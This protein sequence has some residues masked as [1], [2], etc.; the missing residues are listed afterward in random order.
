MT[1]STKPSASALRC[2][3]KTT[4]T[5]TAATTL[6][7]ALATLSCAPETL[8][9]RFDACQLTE[10]TLPAD[11]APDVADSVTKGVAY[12]SEALGLPW[13]VTTEGT[14]GTEGAVRI[15]LRFLDTPIFYGRFEDEAGQIVLSTQ[16]TDPELRAVVMAHE[17]GHALG[18][19]HVEKSER[20][21]V[22][23]P[24]NRDVTPTSA[25]LEA[26]VAIWG[27]CESAPRAVANRT[28]NASDVP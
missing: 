27:R 21:S 17:L 10:I 19:Y 9:Q 28:A 20:S 6:A 4:A 5:A 8:A 14:E 16:V 22:M 24:G 23:N 7:L 12:W 3:R 2:T 1:R 13:S 25:D 18:L 11:T 15:P 26:V